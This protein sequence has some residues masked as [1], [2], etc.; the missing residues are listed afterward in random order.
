MYASCTFC[1]RALG[2]NESIEIFP[3]GRRLAFDASKGRLW[4]VCTGC[5]QWNLTPLE[6]RWEAIEGAERL[7]R[8]SRLRHSTD[9]I[10]LARLRDGTEL[11][12]IGNPLRP[13]MAAWRF[14]WVRMDDEQ[15]QKFIDAVKTVQT[16]Q[17]QQGFLLEM[18]VW[19]NLLNKP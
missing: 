7:F 6:G 5:A 8:E 15:K 14:P 10:G 17:A 4:V 11:V 16:R 18:I 9:N 1:H 12:R 19:S 2:S 3:V 13:E